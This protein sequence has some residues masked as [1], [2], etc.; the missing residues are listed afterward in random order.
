LELI[1]RLGRRRYDAIVLAVAHQQFQ[2]LSAERILALC[3]TR[4]V[5][6]DIKHVLPRAVVTERL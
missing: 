1:P 4:H 3:K 2:E 6:Y 5:V